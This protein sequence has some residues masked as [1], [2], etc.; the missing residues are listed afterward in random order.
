MS[1]FV[2]AVVKNRDDPDGPTYVYKLEQSDDQSSVESLSD[3]MGGK[4]K[5]TTITALSLLMIML[6]PVS[7]STTNRR[8]PP[9][10]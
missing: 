1:A 3:V 2:K 4:G 9:D 10:E 8:R 7:V 6:F 5:M